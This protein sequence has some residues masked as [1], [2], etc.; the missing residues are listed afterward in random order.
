M[1][2]L[3]ADCDTAGLAVIIDDGSYD[4]SSW[5]GIRVTYESSG[6][7]F[8][9][10]KST[11]GSSYGYAWTDAVPYSG[12]SSTTRTILFS[13]F[14]PDSEFHGLEWIQE[15]QFTVDDYG[16]EYGFKLAVHNLELVP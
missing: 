8:V 1:N 6:P 12:S 4:V 16:K 7:I 10:L 15:I 5:Q 11:N 2:G 3:C 14:T 13:D 9:A